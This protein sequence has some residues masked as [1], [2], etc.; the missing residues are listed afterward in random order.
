MNR[1]VLC[2]V[3]NGLTDFLGQI[4]RCC[5]YAEEYN[6]TVVV[7]SDFPNAHFIKDNFSRYY[8]SQDSILFCEP[9]K[10][11]LDLANSDVFPSF[12]K[13]RLDTYKITY[14]TE[15]KCYVDKDYHEPISFNFNRDYTE[16]ALVHQ[17]GERGNA[18]WAL[19]RMR[20]HDRLV[21]ML[22]QRLKFIGSKFWGI[23]VRNTEY[24]TNYIPLIEKVAS[25]YNGT[26]FLA[27]DSLEVLCVVRSICKTQR[28]V[29]FNE[30]SLQCLGP[31]HVFFGNDEDAFKTRND[32][33]I[34]DLYTLA[35]ASKYL[36]LPAE[37]SLLNPNGAYSGFSLLANDLRN[38]K[39]ILRL[40][41]GRNSSTFEKFLNKWY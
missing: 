16:G 3:I 21:E 12:I 41:L 19:M 22:E 35:F 9:A 33:A 18:I 1:I 24:S 32:E 13:G 7:Q 34:L 25:V 27:T 31:Q 17:W 4:E 5:R 6:R 8:L 2:R 23:H 11:D 38:A 37:P 26:I 29:N 15:K 36:F 20:L 39:R 30:S 14:S 28:I 10:E 40:N